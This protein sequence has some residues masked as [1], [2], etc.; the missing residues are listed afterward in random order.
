MEEDEDIYEISAEMKG[1]L[2]ERLTEDRETYLTVVL[3]QILSIRHK[4]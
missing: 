4:K 1:I 3:S 2:D